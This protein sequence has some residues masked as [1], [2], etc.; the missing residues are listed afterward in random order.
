MSNPTDF[1]IKAFGTPS[2]FDPATIA[3]SG[4]STAAADQTK[5]IYGGVIRGET[6]ALNTPGDSI[7]PV[8]TPPFPAANPTVPIT[9]S[10]FPL[11]FN[12][13]TNEIFFYYNS[14]VLY[15]SIPPP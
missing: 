2:A 4:T 8:N 6:K 1:K 12:Y 10:S 5:F 13:Q 3:T 9:S 14:T 11:Y 7:Y 15:P